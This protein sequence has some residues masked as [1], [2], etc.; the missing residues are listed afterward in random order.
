MTARVT[1]SAEE[2]VYIIWTFCGIPLSTTKR[3]HTE[4]HGDIQTDG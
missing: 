3:G 2:S 4:R 1:H